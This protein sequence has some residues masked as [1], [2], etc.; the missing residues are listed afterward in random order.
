VPS[1]T[2]F[3]PAKADPPACCGNAIFSFGN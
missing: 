2:A 1:F 3:M